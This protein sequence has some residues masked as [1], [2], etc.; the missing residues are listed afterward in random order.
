MVTGPMTTVA[1]HSGGL[2]LV[3]GVEVVGFFIQ[4]GIV[5]NKRQWQGFL[6]S[7]DGE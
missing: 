2:L 7:P 4:T 6:I 3:D 5:G 1:E